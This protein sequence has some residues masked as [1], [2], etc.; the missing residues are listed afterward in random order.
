M[1]ALLILFV[2]KIKDRFIL[3]RLED[4]GLHTSGSVLKYLSTVYQRLDPRVKD[5]ASQPSKKSCYHCGSTSHL[6]RH[7]QEARNFR[8]H[9][10]KSKSSEASSPSSSYSDGFGKGNESDDIS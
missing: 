2:L 10:R 7:C 4:I 8:R 9:Q 1:K 5:I 6:K 3:S